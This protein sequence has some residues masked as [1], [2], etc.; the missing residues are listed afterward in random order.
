MLSAATGMLAC[1][2][3]LKCV[4]KIAWKKGTWQKIG[5]VSSPG[6]GNEFARV[7]NVQAI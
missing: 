4:R 2:L 1:K 5:H 7:K 3:H 6:W